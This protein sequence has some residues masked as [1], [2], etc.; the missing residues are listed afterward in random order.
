MSDNASFLAS[1]TGAW[2]YSSLPD[3]VSIG[4]GCFLERRESFDRF[5]SVQQPGLVIGDNVAVYTWTTFNLEPAARLV[6]CDN[7]VIVGATFMCA[8]SISIGRR[9]VLSYNVTVADSD[10]HPTDPEARLYDAIANAPFGDRSQ[11]PQIVSRPVV[12]E[13][14]VWVGIGA[15]ILKGVHI[16]RG[17]RILAGAVV[18][19]N[20]P[21]AAYAAGNPARIVQSD[22]E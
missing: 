6:I 10:F 16:G 3:N 9:C 22:E 1:I 18:T 12:I 15:I 2:D 14:D 13:D 19:S 17:A 4:T 20:V 5:R 7:S 21:A 8:E 11:R